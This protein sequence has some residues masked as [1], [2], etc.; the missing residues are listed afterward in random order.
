MKI[1]LLAIGAIVIICEEHMSGGTYK[2]SFTY[3]CDKLIHMDE[4]QFLKCIVD[5]NRRSILFALEDG[6]RCVNDIIKITKLE[7]TLVS[8]HLKSLK[9]CGLVRSQRQGKRIIYS[10]S[11]LS[12]IDLLK[13]IG[14]VSD[15]I[16]MECRDH[17]CQ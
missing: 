12:I 1:F 9:N 4:E 14:K 3:V 11:D 7:Q 2:Y 8:F 6:E 10:V 16:E 17:G 13:N 5:N 15:K